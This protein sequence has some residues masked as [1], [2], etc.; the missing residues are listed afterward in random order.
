MRQ[1]WH[2]NNWDTPITHVWSNISSDVLLI[3]YT[4]GLIYDDYQNSADSSTMYI[5]S[6]QN[7]S[8]SGEETT[9]GECVV[10]EGDCLTQ[11][12]YTVGLKCFGK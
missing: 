1:W 9:L 6:F 8:C 7:V 2:V 5:S 11:C 4:G 12:S 10:H 3:V